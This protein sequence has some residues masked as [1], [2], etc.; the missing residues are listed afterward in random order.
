[1]RLFVAVDLDERAR[2][3]VAGSVGSLR[4]RLEA[5]AYAPAHGVRWVDARHLH[6]TLHFLGEI[7]DRRVPAIVSALGDPLPMAPF[8]LEFGG[9]GVFPSRGAPRVVWVGVTA[10]AASLQAAHRL[11]GDRLAALGLASES[12][13]LSPHLTVGRVKDPAG[14]RWVEVI[15][16]AI[17]PAPAAC[18]IEHCTLYQSRL[19][20]SGPTYL[21]QAH[22]RLHP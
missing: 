9:W 12:R 10:G 18:R 8:D 21:V 11:V 19:S 22:I 1:V 5:G 20:P 13:A 4:A 3:A 6:L 2:A 16:G 14:A 15:A 7:D 17:P